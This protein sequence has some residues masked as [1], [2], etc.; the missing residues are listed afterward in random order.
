MTFDP[1]TGK[2]VRIEELKLKPKK[3]ARAKSAQ[4]PP[5]QERRLHSKS[6]GTM[7]AIREFPVEQ[8]AQRSRAPPG[9]R[10][11]FSLRHDDEEAPPPRVSQSRHRAQYDDEDVDEG[12]GQRPGVSKN[13]YANGESQISGGVIIDR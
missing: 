5:P 1:V 8:R 13:P 6:A 3:A 4:E 9:G 7:G 2:V 12:Y 10:S 11:S